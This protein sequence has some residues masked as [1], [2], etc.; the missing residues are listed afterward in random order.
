LYPLTLRLNSL[1]NTAI[2]PPMAASTPT[3]LMYLYWDGTNLN[4]Y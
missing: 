1:S 4:L 3:N 2:L